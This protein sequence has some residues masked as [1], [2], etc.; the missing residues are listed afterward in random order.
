MSP[1]AKR[2]DA[3]R[4]EP[5]VRAGE[6]GAEVPARL[7]PVMTE[8]R[9]E[10]AGWSRRDR[11]LFEELLED[12]PSELQR[13]LLRRALAAGRQANELH[14][15]GDA[16]RP[17][18]DEAVFA[19]CTLSDRVAA[20][21]PIEERLQAE[22]DPL[23][24]YE[25]NGG[26]ITPQERSKP[27]PPRLAKDVRAAPPPVR[28]PPG[29]SVRAAPPMRPPQ[30]LEV[31]SEALAALPRT[32]EGLLEL[33][34]S[35]DADPMP[36]AK[37]SPAPAFV[38]GLFVEGRFAEDLFNDALR[39]LGLSLV[40]RQVDGGG[41]SLEEALEGARFALE[42]SVP[43]PVV[44]GARAG[45]Y[46]RYAI[47]LQ[48]QHSGQSRVF[49]LHDPFAHETVWVHEGDFH[50]RRELPLS[51]KVLRQITAIALLEGGR[52]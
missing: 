40:E 29:R 33:G 15:F 7:D 41:L 28:Q 43:V 11:Q 9:E 6:D 12:A 24:A 52:G 14:A 47:L 8:S 35:K 30:D 2:P 39:P 49:Q 20:R 48:V 17:L 37:P 19:A 50:A 25:L 46:R 16:I 13:E 38:E 5:E 45:D 31:D 3:A 51:D 4:L 26:V 1:R 32:R 21:Q 42:N 27:P 34:E 18:S 36:R 10:L 44:L 23:Y 22:A